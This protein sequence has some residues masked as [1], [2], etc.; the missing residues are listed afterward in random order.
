M[1]RRGFFGSLAAALAGLFA[2]LQVSDEERQAET[3]IRAFTSIPPAE[4]VF[5]HALIRMNGQEFTLTVA[6][7]RNRFDWGIDAPIEVVRQWQTRIP[8]TRSFQ[9]IRLPE[10]F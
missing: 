10:E 4:E 9:H 3:Y 1:L 8:D 5:H 6:G 7:P 2:R